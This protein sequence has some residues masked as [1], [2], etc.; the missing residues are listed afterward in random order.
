MSVC[1][2]KSHLYNIFVSLC[3]SDRICSI[4]KS[5]PFYP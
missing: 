3:V 1:K 5:L 4:S 2:I